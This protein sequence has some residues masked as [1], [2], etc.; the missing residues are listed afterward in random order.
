MTI[1]HVGKKTAAHNNRSGQMLLPERCMH[2]A[3]LAWNW[4]DVDDVYGGGDGHHDD[5]QDENVV[6]VVM[7]VMVMVVIM[8]V[9]VM[10][11]VVMSV[12][13]M[14]MVVMVI[15]EIATNDCLLHLI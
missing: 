9:V 5:D 11:V 4:K 13:I 12:V 8:S 7:S 1:I 2:N 6:V 10:T 14:I 3:S 15:Y